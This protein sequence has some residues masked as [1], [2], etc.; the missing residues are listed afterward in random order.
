MIR[1]DGL[2]RAGIVAFLAL[3]FASCG[4][5]QTQGQV[6]DGALSLTI[7][8]PAA[9]AVQGTVLVDVSGAPASDVVSIVALVPGGWSTS[10][11][12]P[13]DS[14]PNGIQR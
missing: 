12:H 3:G 8:G 10:T 7:H 9:G 5:D 11:T 4:D 6:A 14:E 13:S 1:I 2:A